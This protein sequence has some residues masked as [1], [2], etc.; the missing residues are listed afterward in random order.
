MKLAEYLLF[1]IFLIS[2]TP[3]ATSSTDLWDISK[4]SI[5]TSNSPMGYGA[6]TNMFGDNQVDS[7][8]PVEVG[9]TLFQDRY[10][11][12]SVHW[13]EWSSASMI[14]LTGYNLTLS[15]DF[16]TG[17]RGISLFRL[18]GRLTAS[19]PWQ[20]LDSFSPTAHPYSPY[21]ETFPTAFV[22]Y[23]HIGSFDE[24]SGQFFRAEFTQYS[25]VY[26]VRVTELD[27]IATVPETSSA[28]IFASFT[29]L[30]LLRRRIRK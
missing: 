18:Y 14:R 19:G 10:S 22:G 26:G 2:E 1:S 12:G 9:N 28:G 7:S 3:A 5:V 23:E 30:G 16:Q 27:A 24:F 20:L 29:A 25:D 13:V 11:A 4:G 8:Y 6:V 21:G 17:N 15:D